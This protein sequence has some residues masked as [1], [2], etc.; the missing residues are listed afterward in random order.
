MQ[1]EQVN[2]D[3][4]GYFKATE[5]HKEAGRMTYSWAGDS[6]IIIDHTEVNPDFKGRGVGKIILMEIVS[7]ARAKNIKIL[8]LC[9]FAKSVFDKD[10]EI[11]DVL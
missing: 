9:P 10:E 11:R 3:N 7:F 1:I 5:D 2:H 6:R 8:P 4:K